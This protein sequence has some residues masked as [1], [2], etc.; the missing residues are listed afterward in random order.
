[1]KD[2]EDCREK[3]YQDYQET[4]TNEPTTALGELEKYINEDCIDLLNLQ[5]LTEEQYNAVADCI[6]FAFISGEISSLKYR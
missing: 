3:Q 2:I 5:N 4:L 1:M 6:K